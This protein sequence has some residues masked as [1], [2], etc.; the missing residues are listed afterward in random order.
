MAAQRH[1]SP[2]PSALH[3]RTILSSDADTT[4]CPSGLNAADMTGSSWLPSTRGSARASALD[5]RTVL[6]CDADTMRCPSGLNA[7]DI[8]TSSWPRSTS[9]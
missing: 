5:T 9:G 1:R 8:T 4:R 2:L 3:T 7:A 6:S